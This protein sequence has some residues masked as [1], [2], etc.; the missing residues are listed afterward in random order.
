MVFDVSGRE[1]VGLSLTDNQ[2][3]IQRLN[4]GIYF[5]RVKTLQGSGSARLMV[6]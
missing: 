1:V 4:A 5:V 3:D 2:L 6:N